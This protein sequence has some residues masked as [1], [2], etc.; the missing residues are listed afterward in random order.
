MI[1]MNKLVI[2]KKEFYFEGKS[3]FVNLNESF[4]NDI[5][6]HKEVR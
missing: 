2:T 5:K 3:F 6:Y 1:V 4:K